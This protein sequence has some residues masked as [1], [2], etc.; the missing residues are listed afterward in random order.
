MP[1]MLDVKKRR[2]LKLSIIKK[3]IFKQEN[4]TAK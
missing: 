3:Y 4:L 1:A 2:L